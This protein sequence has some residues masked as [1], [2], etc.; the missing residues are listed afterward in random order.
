MAIPSVNVTG[1]V[2]GQDY[3]T[4]TNNIYTAD[5]SGNVASVPKGSDLRDLE[6][7][8]ARVVDTTQTSAPNGLYATAL[9][10]MHGRNS[11]G[12]AIAAAASAGKF[13]LT[14]TLGTGTFLVSEAANSNTKTDIA[15]FEHVLPRGYVAGKNIT[16]TANVQYVLGGGTVGT[17]TVNANAYRT[18][19]DGTQ[20]VDL[21]NV[22][23]ATVP[24]VATDVVFT[25]AGATLNPG[26]R[27]V[28]KVTEVIQDTGASNITAQINGVR[29]S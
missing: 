16:L 24:A 29:L 15:L 20:G 14:V 8:G 27:L 17:H 13:G 4:K 9:P 3:Q 25:I 1:L 10:L 18:A 7:Q 11:D 23:A 2:P 19:N 28:L 12:S 26:D 22:S 5:T 21:I 6:A